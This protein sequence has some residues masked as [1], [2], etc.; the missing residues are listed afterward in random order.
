MTSDRLLPEVQD[1][2]INRY[3]I[4]K[5]HLTVPVASGSLAPNAVLHVKLC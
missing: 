1:R 3:N 4:L 2:N 5:R